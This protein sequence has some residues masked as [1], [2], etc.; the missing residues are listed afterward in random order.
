MKKFITVDGERVML[1]HNMPFDPVN[2]MGK[3]EEELSKM[4]I[5]LDNIPDP[6]IKEGKIPVPHYNKQKGFYYVYEDAPAR[7]AN[8]DDV[9]KIEADYKAKDLDNKMAIAEVYEMMLGG[10]NA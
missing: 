10:A 3:T 1:I 8:M 6:E 7:P 4:G 2:G 9:A 5:L